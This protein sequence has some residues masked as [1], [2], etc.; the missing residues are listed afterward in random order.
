MAGALLL[1]ILGLGGWQWLAHRAHRTSPIEQLTLEILSPSIRAAGKARNRLTPDKPEQ[2]DPLTPTGLAHLRRLEAENLRLR[3]LLAL[4]ASLPQGGMAAEIVGR[5]NIPWQGKLLL[6]KGAS[7]GVELQMVAVTPEG[8][9]GQVDSVTAHTATL[10]PL[11]D[12]GSGIGAMT[13]RTH[14]P[15]ILKG[16]G[17]NLCQLVELS[18]QFDV[19]EDDTVVTSGLGEIF[20][21]GLPLG[22]ITSVT[23]NPLLTS[24]TAVVQPAADP[25]TAEMV[26]LVKR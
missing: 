14:A 6:D 25:V 4:R 3:A 11:T 17:T 20:P 21:K 12:H 15:G 1:L 16:A 13:E 10:L 5:N 18:G 8:V 23:R 2:T 9:L 22:R 7:E 24:R 19:R 26:L